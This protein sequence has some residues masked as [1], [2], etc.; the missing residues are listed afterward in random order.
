MEMI[1]LDLTP[2]NGGIYPRPQRVSLEELLD[3]RRLMPLSSVPPQLYAFTG[4]NLI[5]FYPTPSGADTA[6]LYY[7]PR[8]TA[9][10]NTADDPSNTAFGGIPPEY[11]DAIE[12]YAFWRASSYDDSADA[13]NYYKLYQGRYR[14]IRR[15]V[16]RTGGVQYP[17]MRLRSRLGRHAQNL[18]FSPGVDYGSIR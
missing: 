18:G 16:Q 7:V 9:L 13:M 11:H 5:S 17:K 12:Y 6:T 2:A 1:S 15:E 10:S 3:R 4:A 8:P 14:E